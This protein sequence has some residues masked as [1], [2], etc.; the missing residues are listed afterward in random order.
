MNEN[1][2]KRIKFDVQLRTLDHKKKLNFNS[3]NRKR[4]SE[5]G[6]QKMKSE[7]KWRRIKNAIELKS[8]FKES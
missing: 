2:T 6:L 8:N 7:A 4:Q 3:R 5:I 1:Q